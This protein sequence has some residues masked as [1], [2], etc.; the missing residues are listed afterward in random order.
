MTKTSKV[1]SL[2]GSGTW[3]GSYGLMYKFEVGFENGDVGEYSS[4]AKDQT[5]F[6]IG[7][8]AEY[9]YT[10]GQHP[11]VKPVY[12]A[13][14]VGGGYT[15]NPERDLKIVKQS[16]LKVSIELCNNDKIT[17]KQVLLTADKFVEWVNLGQKVEAIKEDY[18]AAPVQPK[19]ETTDLPF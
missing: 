7:T 4:K 5:K 14:A 1:T 6:V 11:K 16:C 8:E 9:T 10:G 17:L 2:Q 18:I 12:N 19:K 15:P 3:E 13:S